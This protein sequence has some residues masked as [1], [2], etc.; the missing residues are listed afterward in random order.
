MAYDPAVV[1]NTIL[2]RSFDDG[3]RVSP[4]KL[5]K[6]LYFVASEYAKRTDRELLAE[7]FQQWQYGPVVHSV[8]SEFK[9]F[10]ANEISKYAKDATN[11]ALIIKPG[12]DAD[13]D[14]AIDRVWNATKSRTAVDLSRVTHFAGS[15]WFK[16]WQESERYLDDE[17][18][19]NDL[20]YV[21]YLG[22]RA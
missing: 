3:I 11:T 10:G 15:A 22:L 8:Y 5:Q 2:K 20:S 16:A 1:S 18:I 6:I 13:L 7:P 19:K 14:A 4:M 21:D 17:D 9:S 12:S